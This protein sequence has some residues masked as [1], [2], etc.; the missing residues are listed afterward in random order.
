MPIF[1]GLYCSDCQNELGRTR[2][3]D[4]P[5]L[6]Q[7]LEQ[8]RVRNSTEDKIDTTIEDFFQIA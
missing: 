6:E 4:E 1:R 3:A 2:T 5:P 7:W 8:K